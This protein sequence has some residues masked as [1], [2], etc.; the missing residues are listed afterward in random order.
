MKSAGIIVEYNP[1]H[2]GHKYH[3][4]QLKKTC[5][6]QAIIAVCTG[7]Y[8]QRGDLSIIDKFAKTQA[9]LDNGVDLVIELP[10]I[11]TTQNAYVFADK[12]VGL[13][14]RFDIDYLVFGSETGNL[15][16][17]RKYAELPIDVTKLKELMRDG[18]SYP[19]AYGLLSGSLYPNDILAVAY[20]RSLK[21][22]TITPIAIKRTNDY[23]SKELSLIA[24]AT[25]IR[26]ALLQGEDVSQACDLNIEEPVFNKDLYPYLRQSLFTTS[27]QDLESYFL[28]DEGIGNLLKE[29]AIKYADY[30][31]FIG[32]SIS[33]RYTRSR[34]QR[35]LLQIGNKIK[36]TDVNELGDNDYVR[37]LG[38]NQ[39]GQQILKEYKEKVN[40]VTQFK[41]IPE[42]Y[43]QIEWKTSLLYSTLLKDPAAYLKKELRGPLIKR[44]S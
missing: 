25:A 23:L 31:S 4:D 9:A 17:L 26:Q 24:S 19:K 35:T 15:P 30:E 6:A 20:L 29:N 18:T 37:V 28:V 7:N 16:E 38:F 21:D 11:F 43:K 34:I 13:L 8:N 10:Y 33:R 27:S 44:T 12:A 32:N 40:I 3:L 42:P 39:T 2:N 22:S 1:F 5:D 14:K 41:N 36:K